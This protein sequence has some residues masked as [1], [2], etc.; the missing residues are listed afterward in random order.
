MTKNGSP[1]VLAGLINCLSILEEKT[2]M[3]YDA[4]GDKIEM[5]LFKSLLLSIASDS[6]KHSILL[7]GVAESIASKDKS[8]DCAKK[9]GQVWQIVEAINKEISKKKRIVDNELAYTSEKLVYLES[10]LGEEYYVFTQLKTLTLMV[11]EINRLY[12]IDLSGLK[13]IFNSIIDDEERHRQIL[14]QIRE[15]IFS[16]T[17]LEDNSPAVRYKNP[18]SW[19]GALPPTI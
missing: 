3:L 4:L 15:I 19:S 2:S 12:N 8:E 16:K 11:K 1:E 6:H 17:K 5:P 10:N 9:T 13:K 18:D 7:K 14:E